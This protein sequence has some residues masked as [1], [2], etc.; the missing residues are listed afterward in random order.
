MN[1]QDVQKLCE[2]AYMTWHRKVISKE[3]YESDRLSFDSMQEAFEFYEFIYMQWTTFDD[4][5]EFLEWINLEEEY[6]KFNNLLTK[7]K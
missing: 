4:F 1:N 3:T 7:E 5:H 2:I 6:K